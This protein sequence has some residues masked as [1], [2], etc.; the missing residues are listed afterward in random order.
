MDRG[1]LLDLLVGHT[2]YNDPTVAI[3]ELIQ[4]AID[5]VR[6]QCHLDTIQQSSVATMPKLGGVVVTWDESAGLLT[7]GDNGTGMDLDTIRHNL[8]KV[9]ASFYNSPEFLAEHSDFSPI[10][11]FGIGILT[12]FM[13][14]DDIEI[15]T[16]RR[17]KGFR[18]RMTSVHADYLLRELPKGDPLLTGLE[19]HG[20]RVQLRL[21]QSI[22]VS[23]RS[24]LEILRYWVILPECSVVF[25]D[26]AKGTSDNVGSQAIDQA[27]IA[28]DE[29]T[30][31]GSLPVRRRL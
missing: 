4:N 18:I 28:A 31:R 15:I 1:K 25:R 19:P 6:Y 21:R 8:M 7:V 14:S 20:T 17:D 16:C 23:K 12:C 10:S 13:V 22:D 29:Q 27:L 2:I 26:V 9:G 24:I 5:A 3:R 30:G 11:R